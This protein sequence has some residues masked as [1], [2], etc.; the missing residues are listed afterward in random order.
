MLGNLRLPPFGKILHAYHEQKVRLRYPIYIHTGT[1]A[2]QYAFNDITHGSLASYIP[3]AED[4]AQYKWPVEG[5]HVVLVDHGDMELSVLKKI[6][7]Y[8]KI[9]KPRI[10]YLWSKDHK[11]I[12]WKEDKK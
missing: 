1:N 7:F 2:K 10:I 12:I 8:L 3:E 5:Q 4:I 9:Y 11:P 6:M